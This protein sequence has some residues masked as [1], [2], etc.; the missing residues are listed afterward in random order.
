MYTFIKQITGQQRLR[1]QMGTD[2]LEL[3]TFHWNLGCDLNQVS[4]VSERFVQLWFQLMP[5][6]IA[7]LLGFSLNIKY[8]HNMNWAVCHCGIHLQILIGGFWGRSQL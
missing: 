4:V 8:V 2:Q 1:E 7:Y 3:Q 6:N 5:A